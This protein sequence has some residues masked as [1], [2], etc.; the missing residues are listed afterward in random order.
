MLVFTQ[1]LSTAGRRSVVTATSWGLRRRS[2]R[3]TLIKNPISCLLFF[4]V[5]PLIGFVFLV[6][7]TFYVK[8]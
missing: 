7:V 5:F 3:E 8:R 4:V 2:S 6:S 1:E